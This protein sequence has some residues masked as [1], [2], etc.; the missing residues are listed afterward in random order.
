MVMVSAGA[1]RLHCCASNSAVSVAWRWEVG[2]GR[3]ESGEWRGEVRKSE[4]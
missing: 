3:E 1:G 4:K 2:G